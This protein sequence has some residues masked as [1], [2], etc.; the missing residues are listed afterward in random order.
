MWLT[1][2][3]DSAGNL[4]V[5]AS[6]DPITP[7]SIVIIYKA[8]GSKQF[9]SLTTARIHGGLHTI[10]ANTEETKVNQP[11]LEIWKVCFWMVNFLAKITKHASV[12]RIE[13]K[14]D[15]VMRNSN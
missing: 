15:I 6:S 11:N 2:A 14:Q 8:P 7:P 1:A 5:H 10:S 13:N 9:V 3:A 12:S 4:I